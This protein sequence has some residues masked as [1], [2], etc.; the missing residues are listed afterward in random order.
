MVGHCWEWQGHRNRGGYGVFGE[1]SKTLHMA[2]R[3]AWE[4]VHGP[5]P[6]GLEM[7]HLCRNK[8]C[9]R[10]EH[11][12]AVTRSVNCLRREAAKRGEWTPP[13]L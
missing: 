12:E 9:V 13:P 2:H 1:N 11:L 6:E 8:A 10:V 3:Y 4:L 5:V 7:D